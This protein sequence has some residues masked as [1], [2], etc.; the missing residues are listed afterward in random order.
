VKTT[1]RFCQLS[2][3]LPTER[4]PAIFSSFHGKE[5][6]LYFE[7]AGCYNVVISTDISESSLVGNYACCCCCGWSV[8]PRNNRK[9]RKTPFQEFNTATTYRSDTRGEFVKLLCSV[10][11]SLL[12]LQQVP[13]WTAWNLPS[14]WMVHVTTLEGAWIPVHELCPLL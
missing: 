14:D 7:G 13:F 9:R 3:W 1:V 12:V 6:K 8:C 11:L 10:F 2:P 5:W 4:R